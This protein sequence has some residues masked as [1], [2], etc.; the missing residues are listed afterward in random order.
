MFSRSPTA[1]LDNLSAYKNFY[2]LTMTYRLDSDIEFDYGKVIDMKTNQIVAP[3][4]NPKWKTPDNNF[5]G[6]SN[7]LV[8]YP[9]NITNEY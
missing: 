5:Y 4:V 1:V 6:I 8:L 2:N 9:K 3:A 7:A